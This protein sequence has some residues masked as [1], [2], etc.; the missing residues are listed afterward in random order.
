MRL[1]VLSMMLFSLTGCGSFLEELS[2]FVPFLD[3]SSDNKKCGGGQPEEAFLF[4][5]ASSPDKETANTNQAL[6]FEEQPG[7][8]VLLKTNYKAVLGKPKDGKWGGLF[9]LKFAKDGDY[10]F[11]LNHDASLNIQSIAGENLTIKEEKNL[12]SESYVKSCG[13]LFA[14]ALQFNIKAGEYYIE[15]INNTSVLTSLRLQ[16]VKKEE[17]VKAE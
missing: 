11:W 13:N 3:S 9:R 15:V 7:Y 10:T 2:S 1:L 14:R 12:K 17:P 6:N 4:S 8:N 16:I 5:V